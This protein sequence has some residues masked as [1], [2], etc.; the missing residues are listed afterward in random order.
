M[1]LQY[2]RGMHRTHVH[3]NTG[4]HCLRLPLIRDDTQDMPRFEN[5]LNRHRDGL[6]RN[7]VETVE[8][9]LTYLLPATSFIESQQRDT[10]RQFRNQPA[11]R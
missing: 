3:L 6:R 9:T 2:R 10:V 7:F 11:G 4:F 5:L 1:L 8:P